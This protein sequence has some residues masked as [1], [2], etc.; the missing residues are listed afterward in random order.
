MIR[1]ISRM[2]LLKKL[3]WKYKDIKSLYQKEIIS[4][5]GISML[6]SLIV[7]G[8]LMYS[9]EQYIFLFVLQLSVILSMLFIVMVLVTNRLNNI[10]G[11]KKQKG[12]QKI[13][14]TQSL[15]LRNVLYYRRSI[16]ATFLQ[17]LLVSSLA[18]FVYLSL[19]ESVEQTNLTILGQH[20]NASINQQNKMIIICTFLL[21]F[22]TLIENMGRMLEKR[23]DEI[24][25]FKI[26]GW[27]LGSIRALYIK[28]ISLW[29][30]LALLIILR[31]HWEYDKLRIFL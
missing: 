1:R 6:L 12:A 17:V 4:L 10:L 3:G 15:V 11:D 19:A 21:T 16:V 24:S 30:G 31:L 25:N 14:Q 7:V 22:I 29:T 28:E 5:L 8:A 26:L 2:K 13:I 23:K 20:I 27:K 18:S 9:E